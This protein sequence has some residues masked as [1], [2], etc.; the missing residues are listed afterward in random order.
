M[1]T[2]GGKYRYLA[3]N[4]LLLTLSEFGSKLLTFFLVPLYTATLTAREYGIADAVTTTVIL[5]MYVFT[6]NIG[7]SVLRFAIEHTDRAKYVLEY[8]FRVLFAGAVI[9]AALVTIVGVTGI[10]NVDWYVLAFVVGLFISQAMESILFQYLRGIDKVYMMAIAGFMTTLIRLGLSFLTLLVFKWGLLG[11]LVSMMA[12]P[13]IASL[14]CL[15]FARQK[16]AAPMSSDEKKLLHKDMLSYSIPTAV[17]QLGWWINNGIDRYFII[18]IKGAALNGIYAVAYKIP[19]VMAMISNIFCQAWG[20]SAIKEFDKDDKDGFYSN[21]YA[22]YNSGLCILC[23]VLIIINIPVS[24][25]L[26]Q[27]EFFEAWK[28]SSILVMAFLFSG[29][30][31]FVAGAFYAAKKTRLLAI[32]TA[33]AAGIN[34]VLNAVLIPLFGAYGAACA[35]LAAFVSCWLI[36]LVNSRKLIRFRINIIRDIAVYVLLAGQIALEHLEGHCYWGQALIVIAIIA[37]FFKQLKK[38]PVIIKK[39]AAT[40]LNRNKERNA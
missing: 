7:V 5:L 33:I 25:L 20:I 14:F 3:K 39:A 8:A 34:I 11:Y 22:M 26:F 28:Y 31:N 35:T 6:L 2:K 36:N 10:I 12:G 4:T 30:D 9:V 23:A 27:K 1:N 38:Y 37:L 32:A 18:F 15:L 16:D 19:S 21:T 24:R 40:F 29:L 13:L 17:S